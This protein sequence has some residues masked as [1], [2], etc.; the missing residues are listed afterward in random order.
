MYNVPLEPNKNESINYINSLPLTP[1]PEV[2]GLHE[3]ADI[4]KNNRETDL[5]IFSIIFI[6]NL[7]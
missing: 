4:S 7:F 5:V 6:R 2:F 1:N 3:N